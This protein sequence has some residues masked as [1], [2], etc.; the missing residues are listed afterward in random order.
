LRGLAELLG[1]SLGSLGCLGVLVVVSLI[2]HFLYTE[3]PMP[4][5]IG[6]IVVWF[7]YC[8]VGGDKDKKD[9]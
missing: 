7:I 6:L 1:G 5:L 3:L 8:S 4:V 2:S 9:Q